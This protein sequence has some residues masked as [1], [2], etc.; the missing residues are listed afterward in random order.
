VLGIDK[1]LHSAG[2]LKPRQLIS[3][4]VGNVRDSEISALSIPAAD[5]FFGTP[6]MLDHCNHIH[7]GY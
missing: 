7:V 6:T 5:S 3:G 4:G 1:A 2:P